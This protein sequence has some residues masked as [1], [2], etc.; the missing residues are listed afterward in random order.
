MANASAAHKSLYSHVAI[1]TLPFMFILSGTPAL[2]LIF[3]FIVYAGHAPAAFPHMTGHPDAR[4]YGAAAVH[5]PDE[6]RGGGA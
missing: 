4:E 5:A 3:M 2:N 6:P 1:Y